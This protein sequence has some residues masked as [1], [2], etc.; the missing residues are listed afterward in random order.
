MKQCYFGYDFSVSV[1]VIVSEFLIFQSS[2]SYSYYFSVS[3][4]VITFFQFQ[5]QLFCIKLESICASNNRSKLKKA[6]TAYKS[7]TSFSLFH[8]ISRSSL[9]RFFS[10]G[11]WT[12]GF[13]YQLINS[14][15]AIHNYHLPIC[16][17]ELYKRSFIVRSLFNF[18][19]Q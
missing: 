5:L 7:I 4:T 1:S 12:A 17:Y 15:P 8:N 19:Y 14:I 9:I 6:A 10:L 13:S 18:H 11:L 2:Y 3:L 16:K